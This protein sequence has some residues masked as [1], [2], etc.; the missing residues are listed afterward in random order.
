MPRAG[1]VADW[2]PIGR[3][4]GSGLRCAPL[5]AVTETTDFGDHDDRPGGCLRDRSAIRRVFLEA[6][7][8]STP[9]I[10]PDVGR[11]D[12]PKM[13]LVHDDH[14]IETLS[15]DRADQA[16][17]VRIGVSRALHPVMRISH[18]FSPSRIRSIRCAGRRLSS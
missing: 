1:C 7:M 13:R 3:S 16:L 8:R 5:I 4:T 12:A 9:M 17:D 10:V 6:E 18:T 11:E 2:A 15:S 14:V